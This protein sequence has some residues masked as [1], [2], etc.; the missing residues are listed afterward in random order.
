MNVV[1][2]SLTL[3]SRETVHNETVLFKD[4]NNIIV[5]TD[6]DFWYNGEN[7]MTITSKYTKEEFYDMDRIQVCKTTLE[8][9]EFSLYHNGLASLLPMTPHGFDCIP[10]ETSIVIGLNN[11]SVSTDFTNQ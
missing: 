4:I 5:G 7:T 3:K 8:Q 2:D 10:Y 1:I 6:I 11:A 9:Q